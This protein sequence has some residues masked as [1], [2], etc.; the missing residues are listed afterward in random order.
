LNKLSVLLLIGLGFQSTSEAAG[1]PDEIKRI[2]KCYAL[3]VQKRILKTD[4]LYK[5]VKGG[6][7]GT[8]ACM[9]LL[10][11][12]NLDSNGKITGNPK[13]PDN[14]GSRILSTF[15]EFHQK[16]LSSPDLTA[17]SRAPEQAE[18]YDILEPAYQFTYS[19]F[20]SGQKYSD[21][22]TRK[23]HIQAI[24][25][26]EKGENRRTHAV[27]GK[28][29]TGFNETFLVQGSTRPNASETTK[30]IKWDA[31]LVSKGILIGL[32]KDE[33]ENRIIRY[34]SGTTVGN[35][36]VVQH[37]QDTNKAL[38][39]N[40]HLG[41]GGILGSQSY[42]TSL[43]PFGSSHYRAWSKAVVSDL[44]C[45]ELPVLRV[46]DILTDVRENSDFSFRNWPSCM[47]CHSTLDPMQATIRNRV[48]LFTLTSATVSGIS[49][50]VDQL[51]LNQYEYS[52]IHYPES[53]SDSANEKYAKRPPFGSLR[54]RSYNGD[55]INKDV[56]GAQ[57]L[58]EALSE[59]NDLYACAA[60]RYFH[61]LTGIDVNLDDQGTHDFKKS[62]EQGDITTKELEY[63]DRV[64]EL[65]QKLK[66]D[67][68]QSVKKI[69][70]EI[71]ASETFIRPD[72][73]Q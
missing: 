55:P 37:R 3:F 39:S 38:N 63:R 27:T 23:F 18:F 20:G 7:T 58:G 53:S 68:N 67:Q 14:I 47:Q 32:K 1:I 8:E 44:L 15:N 64:I 61:F 71:I 12:A 33:R 60:K 2:Q 45:R 24:R 56:T 49:F 29:I 65:G 26:S 5:A 51:I 6:M 4:P 62:V 19:I 59:T 52:K 43:V 46:E 70:E 35:I 73:G 28:G 54:F 34:V 41:G 9:K 22:V 66:K 10:D 11:K 36:S 40:M 30:A 13:D 57:E 25:H 48:S 69:L 16:N 21:L 72:K 31:E 17:I 42:M 50:W